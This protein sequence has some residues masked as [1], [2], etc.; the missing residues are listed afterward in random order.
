PQLSPVLYALHR[1]YA[2]RAELQTAREIAE[3]HL[4]L[5]Q[6]A[7]DPALLLPAH[8]VLGA[9]FL[10]L[11]EFAPA[12]EHLEQ[13]IASYDPQRHRSLASLYSEHPGVTS[14]GFAAWALWCL[15]YPDQALKRSQEALTLARELSSPYIQ[16]SAL[17]FATWLHHFRREIQ[18]TQERAEAAI[19]LC[20]EQGFSFYLE[21]G[22]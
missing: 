7:Q 12:R 8:L 6:S 21:H 13:G 19:T 14:L 10:W 15:G 3:Q 1:L 11:G 17:A 20:T 22:T 5:A 2:V 9:A 18:L 4:R 16:A